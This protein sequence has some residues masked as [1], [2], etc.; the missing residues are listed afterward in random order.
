ML[1]HGFVQMHFGCQRRQITCA[2]NVLEL[3]V[4]NGYKASGNA[5]QLA[6]E[7][8]EFIQCSVT[9]LILLTEQLQR[10]L[11]FSYRF[12]L[13]LR[14]CITPLVQYPGPLK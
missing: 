7:P 3:V 5:H 8:G 9:G 2:F 6:G 14:T 10:G 12:C 1:T 11:V 4:Y 13:V